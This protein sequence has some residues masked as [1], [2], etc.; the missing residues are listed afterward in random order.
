MSD[1]LLGSTA[2]PLNYSDIAIPTVLASNISNDETSLPVRILQ[3]YPDPP[4]LISIDIGL[5]TQEICLVTAPGLN[6][7]SII[8]TRNYDGQ[9]AFSHQTG[10]QVVHSTTAFDYTEMNHHLYDTSVD[11]HPQYLDTFRHSNI[12]HNI[13]SGSL[14]VDLPGTSNPGD[15]SNQGASVNVSAADHVHGRESLASIVYNSLPP[16]IIILLNTVVNPAF[17]WLPVASTAAPNA[18]QFLTNIGNILSETEFSPPPIPDIW[19]EKAGEFK[20]KTL[21]GT[22]TLVVDPNVVGF[23]R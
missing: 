6:V 12:I 16:G 8:V 21:V 5:A 13:P 22:Y 4:Y 7:N 2:F 11:W 15:P 23:Q 18:F 20:A 17:P 9:G 3:G 14:G 1:T 10:A 19:E